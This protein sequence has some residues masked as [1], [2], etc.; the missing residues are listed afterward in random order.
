M[1]KMLLLTMLV[2]PVCCFVTS[3]GHSVTSEIQ[4]KFIGYLIK[5]T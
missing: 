2:V 3:K 5:I 1:V 4:L